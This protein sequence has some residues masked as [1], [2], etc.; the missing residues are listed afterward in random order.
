MIFNFAF[1]LYFE[2]YSYKI[3]NNVFL[4]FQMIKKINAN[5]NNSI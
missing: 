5:K 3:P 4:Y 2:D 1:I